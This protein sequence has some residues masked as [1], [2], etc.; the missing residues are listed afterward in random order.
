MVTQTIDGVVP[1]YMEVSIDYRLT[2]MWQTLAHSK[3]GPDGSAEIVRPDAIRMHRGMI[4]YYQVEDPAS[5]EGRS[6]FEYKGHHYTVVPKNALEVYVKS[7]T[8]QNHTIY[9]P[10]KF[11]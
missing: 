9:G 5:I 8:H 6:A 3:A 11:R 2:D 10:P 1:K 7:Q 4:G